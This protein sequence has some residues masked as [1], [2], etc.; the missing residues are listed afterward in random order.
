MMFARLRFNFTG[1]LLVIG[2][3]LFLD[4]AG[5]HAAEQPSSRKVLSFEELFGDDVIAKGA[6]LEIKQSQLDQAF[7]A[8]RVN[9]AGRGRSFPERER[10]LKEAQLLDRMI[11]T[12]LL[13]NQAT[14]IDQGLA[15][16]QTD[17]FFEDAKKSAGS[18]EDFERQLKLTGMTS[19]SFRQRVYEQSLAETVLE[20]ELAGK[21]EV[22]EEE[23]RA[24][25]ETGTGALVQVMMS[26]IRNAEKDPATDPEELARAKE[27][28]ELVRQNNLRMLSDPEKASV[29]HVLIST[30]VPN[31]DQQLSDEARIQKRAVAEKVLSEA[32]G[33][34]DFDALIQKY[35]EDRNL[36]ETG[37][38][39][40]LAHQE[41]Y[42]PEFKAACFS[43]KP[44][45][46][47]DLVTTMFGFHIIK[48]HEMIPARKLSYE[49]V[50][51]RIKKFLEQQ[52][53]RRAM[54]THLK[55]V[56]KKA[57]IE[58]LVPKYELERYGQS[59]GA[60]ATLQDAE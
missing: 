40:I 50:S 41:P 10:D 6:G 26:E 36:E 37:G 60:G 58:I 1:L 32:K 16:G 33:G 39:Y 7:L 31:S 44:G 47:S 15:A 14:R 52:K 34:A 59:S 43:L 28:V 56:R 5:I 53:F 42:A 25:Y 24:F 35:S 22:T 55:A 57:D 9:L 11:T 46:I 49:E 19:D 51:P 18:D 29:S 54:A 2:L 17:R 3:A 27:Q 13:T 8:Y 21:I 4:G 23:A 48:L 38:H 45:Q 12:F 20:R 30:R